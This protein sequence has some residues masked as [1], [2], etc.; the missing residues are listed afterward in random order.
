MP[1]I[2]RTGF[3]GDLSFRCTGSDVE[4]IHEGAL[5]VLSRTG[6]AVHDWDTLALLDGAGCQVDMGTRHV[7]IPAQVVRLSLIHI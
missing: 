7:R 4:R 1:G 3:K 5:R 6:I 2:S